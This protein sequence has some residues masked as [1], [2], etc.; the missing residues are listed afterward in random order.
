[1]YRPLQ[2]SAILLHLHLEEV[3]VRNVHYATK[4]MGQD[5]NDPT[6]MGERTSTTQEYWPLREFML[7][8]DHLGEGEGCTCMLQEKVRRYL[9]EQPD[10]TAEQEAERLHLSCEREDH[11]SL[12]LS[13]VIMVSLVLPQNIKR[14]MAR[15][16]HAIQRFLEIESF[17]AR[18]APAQGC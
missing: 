18:G 13:E 8:E 6:F 4:R 11:G 1:M 9:L 15:H 16:C 12:Q 14:A 10:R 5:L 3:T 17:S 2:P 7:A